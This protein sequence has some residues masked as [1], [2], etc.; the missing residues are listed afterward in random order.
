MGRASG[1]PALGLVKQGNDLAVLDLR[2]DV[3]PEPDRAEA[4]LLVLGLE[5]VPDLAHCESIDRQRRKGDA[6]ASRI[7]TAALDPEGGTAGASLAL[8]TI[9][10]IDPLVEVETSLSVVRDR[11]M[12]DPKNASWADLRVLYGD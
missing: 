4:A 9:D 3:A 5:R 1:F 11:V 6:L 7:M 12:A 8:R 2:K 10:A